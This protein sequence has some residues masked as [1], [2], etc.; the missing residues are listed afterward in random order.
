MKIAPASAS[1]S[2]TDTPAVDA[3]GDAAAFDALLASLLPPAAD[4]VVAGYELLATDAVLAGSTE[5]AALPEATPEASVQS[6]LAS[7]Q[8]SHSL[9]VSVPAAPQESLPVTV[10]EA[11]GIALPAS[12]ESL[13]LAGTSAAPAARLPAAVQAAD[14]AEDISETARALPP[15]GAAAQDAE[16]PLVPPATTALP[17]APRSV[18]RDGSGPTLPAALAAAQAGTPAATELPPRQVVLPV[19]PPV[20]SPAWQQAF[21]EQVLWT[22]RAEFQSASLTLNPPDL[23]PVSIELALNEGQASASFSSQQPEVRKAIED[24]LPLLKQMFADAGL[25]LAHADVGTG[26]R[27]PQ[28]RD[29]QAPALTGAQETEPARAAELPVRQQR[30][31]ALLDTYA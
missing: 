8:A 9:G 6:L 5:F 25:Q 13:P 10:P 31:S 3:T 19:A 26:Q 1:P 16:L 14:A 11:A 21:S 29:P 18:E 2:A 4:T 17:A 30:A 12:T 20:A 27:Q 24:A 22:A 28:A 7:V 23:G 15:R